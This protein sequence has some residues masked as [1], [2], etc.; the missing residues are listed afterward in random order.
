[1]VVVQVDGLIGNLQEGAVPLHLQG[2]IERFEL[3]IQLDVTRRTA[4]SPWSWPVAGVELLQELAGQQHHHRQRQQQ[5]QLAALGCSSRAGSSGC[6]RS[7]ADSSSAEG[8][9]RSRGDPAA[10]R[11]GGQ[12]EGSSSSSSGGPGPGPGAGAGG[13]FV[14]SVELALLKP[15]CTVRLME[16]PEQVCVKGLG[17]RV[18]RWPGPGV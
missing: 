17:C 6:G 4:A 8:S 11:G 13:C 18:Q 15:G 12:L 14:E 5:R 2:I 9:G 10:V 7:A 1:V 16:L 3:V